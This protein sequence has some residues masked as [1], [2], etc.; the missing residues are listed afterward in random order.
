[1]EEKGEKWK[2]KQKEKENRSRKTP[3]QKPA[4]YK[5]GRLIDGTVERT[6]RR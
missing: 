4:R 3:Q 5:W 1:M 2:K 6:W